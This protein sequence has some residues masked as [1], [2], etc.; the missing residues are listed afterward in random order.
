SGWPSIWPCWSLSRSSARTADRGMSS[1]A[2]RGD[3][4]RSASSSSA[5][6]SWPRTCRFCGRGPM[7]TWGGVCQCRPNQQLCW[8]S[9]RGSQFCVPRPAVLDDGVSDPQQ[10]PGDRDQ[11]DRCRLPLRLEPLGEVLPLAGQVSW[12][13]RRCERIGDAGP[14]RS[15]DAPAARQLASTGG[16]RMYSIRSGTV[17]LVLVVSAALAA[18]EPQDRTLTPAEQY[19][20]LLK[21]RD[22]LPDELSKAKTAEERKELR[23]RLASLPLRFLQLAEKYPKDPVAVEALTQTVALAHGSA[24]PT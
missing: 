5:S 19:Q 1:T 18:R 22:Q 14:S 3:C 21:E 24:F 4:C 8:V 20:L 2:R 10:L 13:V 6:S 16:P 15:A 17:L 7:V 12:P 9:S 11:G 23:D